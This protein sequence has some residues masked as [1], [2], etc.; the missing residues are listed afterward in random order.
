M[1]LQ[2]SLTIERM[3]QLAEVSRA[4]FYRSLQQQAP[5]EEEMVV[6]ARVQ[7]VVLAHQRRYGCLRVTQEF[8]IKG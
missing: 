3:C 6:R 2:S 8:G 1:P 4:G 7:E 5:R